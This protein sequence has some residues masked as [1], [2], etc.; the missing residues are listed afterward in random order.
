MELKKKMMKTRFLNIFYENTGVDDLKQLII[1]ASTVEEAEDLIAKDGRLSFIYAKEIK[2]SRFPKGE[3]AIAE[4]PK[5]AL[6]YARIILKGKRI[7]VIET[8]IAN[9]RSSGTPYYYAAEI[10]KAPFPE[11]EDNIARNGHYSFLYAKRVLKGPF[12]KGEDALAKHPDIAVDYA[13]YVLKDRFPKGEPAIRTNVV[14]WRQYNFY[15]LDKKDDE[16]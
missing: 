16:D 5:R 10:L 8:S 14:Y 9:S 11:G 2:K 7:D 3:T 6:E 1:N 4:D 15:I 12:P 13:I